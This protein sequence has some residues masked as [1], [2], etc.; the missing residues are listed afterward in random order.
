MDISKE[1]ITNTANELEA[2]ILKRLG[3]FFY[4]ARAEL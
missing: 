4:N 2:K 1:T 3:N